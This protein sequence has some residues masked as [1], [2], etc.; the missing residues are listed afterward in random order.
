[1]SP[2]AG[3]SKVRENAASLGE[4]RVLEKRHGALFCRKVRPLGSGTQVTYDVGGD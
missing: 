1:M 3:T 4:F 2:E